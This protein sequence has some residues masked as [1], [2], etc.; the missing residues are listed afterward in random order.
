MSVQSVIPASLYPFHSKATRQPVTRIN[1]D[2]GST[3]CS[4]LDKLNYIR[5]GGPLS[6][7]LRLGLCQKWRL[8]AHGQVSCSC[9]TTRNTYSRYQTVKRQ[10]IRPARLEPGYGT[11]VSLHHLPVPVHLFL[12]V[13]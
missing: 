5:C 4:P 3:E 8:R 6:I 7:I 13:N 10:T 2:R 1:S 9:S 12:R 11:V